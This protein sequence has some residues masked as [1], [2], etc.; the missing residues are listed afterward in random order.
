M[1]SDTLKNEA[2][3]WLRYVKKN[4]LVCSE[5]GRWSADVLGLTRTAATE[6]EVK[7]SRSDLKAEFRT[8]AGK[9]SRYL[10]PESNFRHVPNY[11]YFFVTSELES[12]A[13]EIVGAGNPKAGVAVWPEGVNRLAGQNLLV[14]RPAT[15]LHEHKPSPAFKRVALM[16]MGSELCGVRNSNVELRHF[17]HSELNGMTESVIKASYRLSGGLDT[18]TQAQDL[19][20]RAE[21]LAAALGEDWG[22][23]DATRQEFLRGAAQKL[24]DGSTEDVQHWESL[25]I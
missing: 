18:E 16:R 10:N 24:L 12:A 5:A 8:K 21:E 13:L 14:S 7:V 3:A 2:M 1:N 19:T 9:H 25:E 4:V 20:L 22:A 11:L 15:K 6:V 23:I 17:I